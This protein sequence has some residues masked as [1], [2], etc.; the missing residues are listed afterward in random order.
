VNRGQFIWNLQ[1]DYLTTDT[2][3]YKTKL[4]LNEIGNSLKLNF[5]KYFPFNFE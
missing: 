2:L 3:F 4:I 5:K 1:D